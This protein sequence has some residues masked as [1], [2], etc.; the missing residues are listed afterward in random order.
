[1]ATIFGN[2]FDDEDEKNKGA[3]T[4]VTTAEPTMRQSAGQG[5]SIFGDIFSQ[6][7]EIRKEAVSNTPQVEAVEPK[8]FMA[9]AIDAG[10]SVVKFGLDVI[11]KVNQR[12]E[13]SSLPIRELLYGNIKTYTNPITGSTRFTTDRL[14]AFEKA[15]TP[16]ERNKIIAEA[17]QDAPIIKF[18]NNNASTVTKISQGTSNLPLKVVAG[19]SALGD[20]TYEEAYGAWLTER[21]DPKNPTWQKFLYEVQDAVPQSLIGVLLAV[22]TTAATRNP[23]VGYATSGA[24]YT[25]LSADEQIQERGKVESVGNLAIDVVGDQLLN[26][27]LIGL[28]SAGGSSNAIV[29]ALK[30]M[31]IEGSTEVSQSLLKYSNDYSNART[32][33]EKD[34]V[35]VNAKNYVVS[36]GILME[37]GVGAVAGGIAA[38]A[39]DAVAGVTNVG[40][41]PNQ[42]TTRPNVASEETTMTKPVEIELGGLDINQL[43]DKLGDFQ[44]S[45]DPNSQSDVEIFNVMQDTLN[46]YATTFNDK[47]FYVPSGTTQAPLLEVETVKF[48]DGKYAVKYSV[49][50]DRKGFNSTYDFTQLF[51]TQKA[52]T[53]DAINAIKAQIQTELDTNPEPELRAQYEE[54]LA[55][56][57]GKKKS[58]VK[59]KDKKANKS[60]VFRGTDKGGE[61][62]ESIDTDYG[63]GF[64][65]AK[66]EETARGYGKKVQSYEVTLKNP[67]KVKD[68]YEMND[69]VD[70]Y[71]GK[72]EQGE[73]NAKRLREYLKEQGYDGVDVENGGLAGQE[74]VG[75]F[76]IAFDKSSVTESRKNKAET[77]DK[78]PKDVKKK[79]VDAQKIA[80]L[81]Q[82]LRDAYAATGEAE[83][84]GYTKA[85]EVLSL[86]ATEME[87]AR[88][89]ERVF[90][91]IDHDA[92]KDQNRF[93]GVSSTFPEWVPEELR[94]SDLFSKVLGTLEVSKLKYPAGNRTRQ[95]ELYQTILGEL[96]AQLGIDT[97]DIR[98]QIIEEYENPTQDSEQ[99]KAPKA[100][101]SSSTGGKKSQKEVVEEAVKDKAK[102]IKEIADETGILE[103]N[104][105]RILGVGAKEGV[106]KRVDKGVYILSTE[107]EGDIAFIYPE[108]ALEAL[109]RLAKEGLKA[110]M[111]FL[112]IPYDTPAVKGGNRGV[113]YNLISLKDFGEVIEAV[114]TIARSEDTPIFHMYSQAESGMKKMQQYNDLFLD[115]GY[116][117]VAKGEYQKT[118]ADGTPVGFPTAKGFTITK[119]EGILVFTKSGKLKKGL[120]ALDF[121]LVR[122]KGY[123]T[124]KPAEML[125]AMVEMSTEEGDVVLDPFAGSGVTGAEAVKLR[126]RA[127]LIEK[128]KDVVEKIITPRVESAIQGRQNIIYTPEGLALQAGDEVKIEMPRDEVRVGIVKA[129]RAPRT[130]ER[131]GEKVPAGITAD[132]DEAPLFGSLFDLTKVKVTKHKLTAE[133]RKKVDETK[134]EDRQARDFAARIPKVEEKI[135]GKN[136][137]KEDVAFSIPS[138]TGLA[139]RSSGEMDGGQ[140]ETAPAKLPD[141][142]GGIKEINPIEL[143]E[144]VDIARELMGKVPTVKKNLGNAAGMFRHQDGIGIS[145]ID[146]IASYFEEKNLP[147]ASKT[148]AHELGHLTDWLPDTTLNRGNLI[149][150]LKSLRNFMQTTF[151]PADG[152]TFTQKDRAKV[153]SEVQ[154]EVMAEKGVKNAK[155]LSVADKALIRE[156]YKL[157]VDMYIENDGYIKNET[158][159]KELLAVTRYWHPYNPK[160]APPQYVAYRES[161]RE[162]YAE[163][164]SML[165][166]APKRLSE[167][168]P[169]FYQEFF[170]GLDAK[171]SVRDVYFEI[172]ALL[173]GDR[174]LI[175]KRRREGVKRMFKDGDYK[176]IELH[177]RMVD[178]KEARRKR[179]WEHFKHTVIDKNY[180]IIDRVKKAEREG[181]KINPDENPVYFLEERN[182]IGGKIKSVFETQF[183]KIY[184][185]LNENEIVWTD[186]GEVLFYERIAAGDRSDVANPRGI[187]P[188]AARELLAKMEAEYGAERWS[189]I[190]KQVDAFR[191]QAKA[192]VTD[193]YEAGLYKPELYQQMQENPAYVSFQ[194]LDYIEN[195]MTSR[196]YKSL[197]TLKD[198]ANP[199]DSTMLKVISTIRA[200][201]RNRTTQ[202]TVEFLKSNFPDEIK[203]A[204]YTA[205]KKGRFPIPSKKPDE[206]LITVFEKGVVK[207]YYID[208]YIAETINNQSYGANAPII[209]AIRFMNSTFFRPLFIQFNLG[210]QTMNLIRDFVRFYKNQPQMTFIKAIKRYGEAYRLSKVRAFGLPKNPSKL[211]LEAFDLLTKAEGEG[212]LGITF[213]D[214]ISGRL[215]TDL[216][217]EKILAGTGIKEFQ[218][219]PTMDKL[220]RFAKPAARALDKAGILDV[221]GAILGF[222]ENLGNLI[223]TL[224]K[225]AGIYEYQGKTTEFLSKEEKSF[226]RRKIGSPDFQAGGTYK[227]IT[228]E[229]FLF[230]NAILQGIRSDIEV[231]T[232]PKTRSGWWWKTSKIAFLP[233]ILMMAALYG[234][235]GDEYKEMMENVSEYDRTN[236]II[237]PWGRDENNKVVYLR[238][239]IDE[240]SRFLGGMLWKAMTL[241]TSSQNIVRDLMDI[242]SYTGGNIPSVSPAITVTAATFQYLSGQNP[243]DAFRGRQVISDTVFEAGGADS[244]KAFSGWLFQ[245]LGGGIFYK[246]YHEPTPPREQSTAEK[247]FNLPVLGNILGR[248]VRVSDYGKLEE[249]RS[250]EATANQEQARETLAERKLVNEYVRTAQEQNIR[251]NTATIERELVKDYFNGNPKTK[252]DLQ[253][254]DRLVKKFKLQLKRGSAEPEV[255]ALID[256][257]TNDAKAAI[258]KKI[259]EDMTDA[260]FVALRRDLISS[261]VVSMTVFEKLQ[262][263]NQ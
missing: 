21:N 160:T 11:N 111:I 25:A 68:R 193:A 35:L 252:E 9:K 209:P 205:S 98:N 77:K 32:Q 148:L 61:L 192:V 218:P 130:N 38:G 244:A 202:K 261:G 224:P 57:E 73:T 26:R 94:S 158:I 33:A 243:Y 154:R 256:A 100:D 70:D 81:E 42:P 210:F 259:R 140:P 203:E 131:T 257:N 238:V 186:F 152:S 172:Q 83:L 86:I 88:P 233:K 199:A 71:L 124:E 194:V 10:K 125:A 177:N 208:P 36:G 226:I 101:G 219:K 182:Y 236:Y 67:L 2:I 147:Q 27:A 107:T 170:K 179:Y 239:P 201:E 145:S 64:Y 62:K 251:F 159:E 122:P 185:T 29:T 23:Q 195:G 66:K 85:D 240:T 72:R 95:R 114:S 260:E 56:A 90:L 96:D 263:D 188:D 229:V 217:V 54:I 204:K 216:Q 6:Q 123:Q 212:V 246:F 232:E 65:F 17:R 174:E 106:F 80:A 245:Q 180:Q 142:M 3:A 163:A 157:R 184:S 12:N 7:N 178:E 76:I 191:T 18:L 254:A 247:F 146:I 227:P 127:V 200:A 59:A 234:A 248:F 225:A 39:V 156:R 84:E 126:R 237:I 241:A 79:L 105:R 48:P 151:H 187:T 91:D 223:E 78:K 15:K 175:T 189:I 20:K 34:A 190:K 97:S 82:E 196:V 52:A 16:E 44:R 220:P 45:F 116:I 150:R 109:P 222:V 221:T 102:T 74:G 4:S 51:P 63:D 43:R 138:G 137:L 250:V 129:V 121:T 50:T 231:A 108:D 24:F 41:V 69:I 183:N 135:Q 139:K 117:P 89:G 144:L 213:N 149:G 19:L 206:E 171:P 60:V 104:V 262:L 176:A 103:P 113:N 58:P 99:G 155:E 14:D 153:R 37:F 168:A 5:E 134:E 167:M 13:E 40:A 230:S 215:D 161:S 110:D 198:I 8:G 169:T 31:G 211:D 46:D 119:P 207:G 132:L 47:T 253:K 255:A 75:G 181:K 249:L 166:V 92:T 1:M 165:F 87:L 53:N 162:L 128:D 228:N 30:G 115:Y 164:L 49:N 133:E 242:A 173:S 120:K 214:I 55:F 136:E 22:G 112:D 93:F 197:G 118:Y 235:F 143:P 141:I 258:L 28:F